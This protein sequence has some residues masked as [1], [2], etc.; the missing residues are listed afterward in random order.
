MTFLDVQS[1]QNNVITNEKRKR[2]N[3]SV[4]AGNAGLF[5]GANFSKC[6]FNMETTVYRSVSP[7]PTQ[8]FRLL[9]ERDEERLT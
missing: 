1:K 2:N 8:R 9:S 3:S 6:T 7:R 5:A 4:D